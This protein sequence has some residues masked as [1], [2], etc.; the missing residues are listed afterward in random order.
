[1]RRNL[2]ADDGLHRIAGFALLSLMVLAGLSGCSGSGGGGDEGG[3][4]PSPE[5]VVNSL[6]DDA[7]PPAGTVTLRSALASAASGQR[8]T[9]DPT[10]NGGTIDLLFDTGQDVGGEQD[11]GALLSQRLHGGIKIRCGGGI[12]AGGGFIE[13]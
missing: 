9:F 4:S 10:L 1:M 7:A 12:E 5:I 2:S 13:Q 3:I 6:L 11:G 8:I